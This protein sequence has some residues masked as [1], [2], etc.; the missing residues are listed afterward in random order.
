MGKYLFF[1]STKKFNNDNLN[2]FIWIIGQYYKEKG[3]PYSSKEYKLGMHMVEVKTNEI[4]KKQNKGKISGS[5]IKSFLHPFNNF[6]NKIK[7]RL[8]I[9]QNN[10]ICK[11]SNKSY[12]IFIAIIDL[13]INNPKILTKCRCNK[14]ECNCRDNFIKDLYN[15]LNSLE[16]DFGDNTKGHFTYKKLQKTN[17]ITCFY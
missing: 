3:S 11:I 1:H 13:I 9:N 10:Y 15:E 6:S 8:Y 16:Y 4:L 14:K 5:E 12:Y 7:H 17:N 2:N